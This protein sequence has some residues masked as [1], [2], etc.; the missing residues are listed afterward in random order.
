MGIYKDLMNEVLS[1][2]LGVDPR[3]SQF[4]GGQLKDDTRHQAFMPTDSQ[5]LYIMVG[6]PGSGKSTFTS[7]LLNPVICSADHFHMKDGVYRWEAANQGKAHL[8]CQLKC[9]MNLRA[10]MPV[11]VVDNT[12]L[13]NKE[14]APYEALAE[15]Y[16][17]K[18]KYVVFDPLAQD[19]KV[20]AGRNVH[21]VTLEILERM[22]GKYVAPIGENFR[23]V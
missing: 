17:Y 9:K 20:L 1:Q 15:T 7:T 18:V 5:T 11:V 2:K 16:G 22:Q 8:E 3:L 6:L 12:N 19:L 13:T 21:G 4:T 14:R 10:G 23:N